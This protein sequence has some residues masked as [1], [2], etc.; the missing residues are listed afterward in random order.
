MALT[1]TLKNYA[2]SD[3][4]ISKQIEKAKIEI[5]GEDFREGHFV[6]FIQRSRLLASYRKI[7]KDF[8]EE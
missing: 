2:D 6:G 7:M 1:R 8:S 5:A 4:Q 3:P